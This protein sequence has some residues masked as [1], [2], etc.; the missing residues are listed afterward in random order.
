MASLRGDSA[1]KATPAVAGEHTAAGEA[2][3]GTSKAGVGV[4]GT[5]ETGIGAWGGSKSSSGVGGMSE[6]GV[7]V[8]GVSKAGPGVR[9]DAENG[10]GVFGYSKAATGVHGMTESGTGVLGG[11]QTGVAV[12]GGSQTSSGV[13]G[14]SNSGFGVHGVSKSGP[15][16]RGDSELEEGVH[17]EMKSPTVAAI[18]A[19]NLNPAGTGAAIFAKKEGNSG[20]A[21]F[22][23]GNVQVTGNL[24]AEGDISLQNADCA[25]EFDLAADTAEPGTVM[26]LG[27]EGAL[28]ESAR[29]YDKRVAGVISGAGD[30]KP[31]IVLDKKHAARNRQPVALLGKVFCKVDAAYAPIEIGDLLTTSDTPGHAMKANS[32][33]EAFGAVIGKALRPLHD[34]RGLI[35]ILVALQ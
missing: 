14:M 29:A 11:S 9:G 3:R 32:P 2:V 13:G 35:P 7:G 30:Y 27:E 12:W 16:V 6:T 23:I 1:V 19:F 4:I 25:E 17:G 33:F 10:D 26:V 22:F 8:H 18:A 34:G 28:H 31:A 15:G 20:H 24:V 21:G 5:S